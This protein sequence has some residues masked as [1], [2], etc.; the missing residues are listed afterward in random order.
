MGNDGVK[1]RETRNRDRTN[2]HINEKPKKKEKRRRK[3]GRTSEQ[4]DQTKKERKGEK[5]KTS[6]QSSGKSKMRET[7]SGVLLCGAR[8]LRAVLSADCDERY[9]L[10]A[11][12]T[13]E[14]VW[15][16]TRKKKQT[17]HN[18]IH[19]QRREQMGGGSPRVMREGAMCTVLRRIGCCGK[20]WADRKSNKQSANWRKH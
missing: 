14:R 12:A 18:S 17:N 7:R 11:L 6:K 20:K 15:N 16:P 19:L 9:E 4:N 13:Y 1:L 3:D 8:I 10:A 2:N 5:N